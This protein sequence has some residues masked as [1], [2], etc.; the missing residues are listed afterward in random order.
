VVIVHGMGEHR[1]GDALNGFI[2]A[3]LP[4]DGSGRRLFYSRP[5]TVTDSF[6]ARRYIA[7]A[8]AARPQ[9][10]FFEY[11]WAHLM[12]GN[13]LDDLWP[14]FRRMLLTNPRN[15]PSGLRLVWLL[16]WSL[17]LWCAWARAAVRAV[18]DRRR[19]G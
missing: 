12:R 4:A 10:E 18:G 1:P 3:G 2:N 13:R 15:V 17:I 19:R 11:H 16:F 9:T 5:D 7:P 14:T 8:T 6:E